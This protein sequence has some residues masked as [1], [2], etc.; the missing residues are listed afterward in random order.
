MRR[1]TDVF[2]QKGWHSAARIRRGGIFDRNGLNEIYLRFHWVYTWS[3]C[4]KRGEGV[5]SGE[6]RARTHTQAEENGRRLATG[7]TAP[8][9]SCIFCL[10]CVRS[11]KGGKEGGMMEGGPSEEQEQ[12][13]EEERKVVVWVR[14]KQPL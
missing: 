10:G 12:M 11:V 6:T 5:G 13:T 9:P 2:A 8:L 7:P 4:V 1:S 14:S 3:T